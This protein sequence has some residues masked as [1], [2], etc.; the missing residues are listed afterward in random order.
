[1]YELLLISA[2]R[3]WKKRAICFRHLLKI[4]LLEL[5]PGLNWENCF[6]LLSQVVSLRQKLPF[7]NQSVWLFR[8]WS[9]LATSMSK[10]ECLVLVWRWRCRLSSS[11]LVLNHH[12]SLGVFSSIFDT[13]PHHP[14]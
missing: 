14:D 10:L 4:R 7:L 8:I 2:K 13:Y 12:E 9:P 11:L 5:I 1:M 3:P 6:V